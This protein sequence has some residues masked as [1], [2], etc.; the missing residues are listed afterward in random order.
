MLDP[1]LRLLWPPPHGRH[2]PPCAH[3]LSTRPLPEPG[4]RPAPEPYLRGEDS[5]LVRP[6]H[7]LAHKHRQAKAE[8]RRQ[9]GRRPRALWLAVYGI[10]IGPRVI[11]GREVA[12]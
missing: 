4:H 10:D 11:H 1:L 2:R 6:P 9:R 5:P 12:A 7:L 8:A 3:I